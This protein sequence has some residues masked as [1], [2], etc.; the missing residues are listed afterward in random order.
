MINAVPF[1]YERLLL[2]QFLIIFLLDTV[3]ITKE[4]DTIIKE[5]A[6][7]FCFLKFYLQEI[8]LGSFESTFARLKSSVPVTKVNAKDYHQKV[9][10][11][12]GRIDVASTIASTSSRNQV[13]KKKT[14]L[15]YCNY[16]DEICQLDGGCFRDRGAACFHL[17]R[18]VSCSITKLCLN[19]LCQS[20]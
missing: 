6:K 19:H 17:A 2:L 1:Y 13:P 8:I 4:R 20:F 11:G 15:C 12:S 16:N 7:G 9:R 14:E 18:R 3:A 5:M 10:I